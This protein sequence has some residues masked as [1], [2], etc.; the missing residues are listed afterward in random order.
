VLRCLALRMVSGRGV[1]R[2]RFLERA[3][4]QRGYKNIG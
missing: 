3:L 1:A 4:N 2:V